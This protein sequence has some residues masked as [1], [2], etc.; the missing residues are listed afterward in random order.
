MLENVC[1]VRHLH[2]D[3]HRHLHLECERNREDAEFLHFK[4]NTDGCLVV[5]VKDI[6]AKPVNN[7]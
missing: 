6:M 2:L 7:N 3:T 5:P 1:V 4:V